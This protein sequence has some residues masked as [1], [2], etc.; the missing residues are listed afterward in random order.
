[1]VQQMLV[2]VSEC[3]CWSSIPTRSVNLSGQTSSSEPKQKFIPIFLL[4][5]FH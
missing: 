5:E 2:L 3:L 4:L 1:M